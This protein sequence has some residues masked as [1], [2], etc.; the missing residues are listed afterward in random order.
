MDE[1]LTGDLIL[2]NQIN[3]PTLLATVKNYGDIASSLKKTFGLLKEKGVEK[4]GFVSGPIANTAETDPVQRRKSIKVKMQLMRDYT[5]ILR[6]RNQYPIFSSTDIFDIVWQELEE[7]KLSKEERAKKMQL[8]FRE[9][10][11]NGV[12]D[13]FMM[14]DWRD[15]PGAIDEYETAKEIGINIHDLEED[16]EVKK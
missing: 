16:P 9:I 3:F 4:I 15:S 12:T 13:I 1:R 5:T 7:T 10:L 2:N 14:K 11:R 8:L 6:M